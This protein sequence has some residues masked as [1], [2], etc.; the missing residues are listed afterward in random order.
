M[1]EHPQAQVL[2]D[3]GVDLGPIVEHAFEL[4]P[5][6]PQFADHVLDTGHEGVQELRFERESKQF[7]GRAS[8]EYVGD[9]TAGESNGRLGVAQTLQNVRGKNHVA[10]QDEDTVSGD[11]AGDNLGQR[12]QEQRM[13]GRNQIGL[14]P[15][16]DG[17]PLLNIG[18]HNPNEGRRAHLPEHP[19]GALDKGLPTDGDKVL[20]ALVVAHPGL[21]AVTHENGHDRVAKDSHEV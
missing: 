14:L 15:S 12:S 4:R 17:P 13:R 20:V 6:G 7:T 9:K 3:H 10:A 1:H 21:L 11:S 16:H 5:H 19:H 8:C 2:L 18:S